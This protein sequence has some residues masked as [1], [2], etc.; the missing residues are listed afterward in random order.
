MFPIAH[1][2]LP[3]SLGSA[4]KTRLVPRQASDWVSFATE[5][6]LQKFLVLTGFSVESAHKFSKAAIDSLLKILEMVLNPC[7]LMITKIRSRN[8]KMFDL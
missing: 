4:S 2:T 1:F 3:P 5:I 7:Y 6:F 8:L